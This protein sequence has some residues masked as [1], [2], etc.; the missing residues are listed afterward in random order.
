MALAQDHTSAHPAPRQGSQLWRPSLPLPDTMR[1][2]GDTDINVLCPHPILSVSVSPASQPGTT[3]S[4]PK[5]GTTL[6]PPRIPRDP[7]RNVE[8]G[9]C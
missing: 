7:L 4:L 6:Q 2:R 3:S 1:L 5:A 9:S 8:D